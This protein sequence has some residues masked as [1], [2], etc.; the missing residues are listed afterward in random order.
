MHLLNIIKKPSLFKS[1]SLTL[2][3]IY[4]MWWKQKES[5]ISNSTIVA[6][7]SAWKKL[8]RTHKENFSDI[9]LVHLQNCMDK[10]G[11]INMVLKEI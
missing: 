6:Y 11:E 8:Y 5:Q 4:N 1:R 10:L 9:R 7:N 3:D 2:E